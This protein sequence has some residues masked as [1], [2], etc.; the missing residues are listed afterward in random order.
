MDYTWDFGDGSTGSGQVTSHTYAA[1]SVATPRTVTL[2]VTDD[3]GR[4][5]QRSNLVTVTP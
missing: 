4:K 3:L 1:V 2:T 5:S